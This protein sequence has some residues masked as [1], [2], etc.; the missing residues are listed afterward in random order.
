MFCRL[1]R[2]PESLEFFWTRRFYWEDR[3]LVFVREDDEVSVDNTA[4]VVEGSEETYGENPEEEL[5]EAYAEEN[6]RD[7]FGMG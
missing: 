1:K 3:P 6:T 2:G 7:P 5:E 4:F